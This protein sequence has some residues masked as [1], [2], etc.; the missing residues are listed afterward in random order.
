[1]RRKCQNSET[2]VS[3]EQSLWSSTS[4]CEGL[5]DLSNGCGISQALRLKGLDLR[6]VEIRQY[7]Q[8]GC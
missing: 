8:E 1:M 4:F 3:R 7:K 2:V 5:D 6:S